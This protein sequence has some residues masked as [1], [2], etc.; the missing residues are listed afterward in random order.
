MKRTLSSAAMLIK[1]SEEMG[2][3]FVKNR[4]SSKTKR[5][6]CIFGPGARGR[7]GGSG[8]SSIDCPETNVRD[9]SVLASVGW[10]TGG[11]SWNEEGH[12]EVGPRILEKERS[13]DKRGARI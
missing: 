13:N 6:F 7:G 5:I 4:L 10:R 1:I 12:T 2:N 9:R 11:G 8:G 3:I